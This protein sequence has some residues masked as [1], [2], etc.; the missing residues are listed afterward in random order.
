[1][2]RANTRLLTCLGLLLVS[3]A[4]APVDPRPTDVSRSRDSEAKAN[5]LET[6]SHARLALAQKMYENAWTLYRQSSTG[7]SIEVYFWSRKV[8]DARMSLTTSNADRVAALHEHRDRM[9]K[10]LSLSR[11]VQKLGFS[12]KFDMQEAEYYVLEADYDLALASTL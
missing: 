10:I 3:L 8:M 12:R 9:V 5:R 4:A 11:K 7:S 6:I 1:M 2:T